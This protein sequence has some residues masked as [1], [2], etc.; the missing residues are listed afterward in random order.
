MVRTGLRWFGAT[1]GLLAMA[2]LVVMAVFIAFAM[3]VMPHGAD[4]ID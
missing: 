2:Y 1:M 4:K 3:I